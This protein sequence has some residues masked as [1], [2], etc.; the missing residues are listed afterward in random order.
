M[1][2][3]DPDAPKHA[4]GPI[5]DAARPLAIMDAPLEH[6]AAGGAD[7]PVTE[8]DGIIADAQEH[9]PDP[10]AEPVEVEIIPDCPGDTPPGPEP[11]AP[12]LGPE[13][14]P[15]APGGDAA[16]KALAKSKA[17][18][19]PPRGGGHWVPA[20]DRCA[21]DTSDS[22]SDMITGEHRGRIA[23]WTA[24]EVL[25]FTCCRCGAHWTRKYRERDSEHPERFDQGRPM[26]F[27]IACAQYKCSGDQQDHRR[28]VA[29]APYT[30]RAECRKWAMDLKLFQESF[31]KERPPWA[32]EGEEPIACP[33]G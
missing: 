8:I 16:D 22:I 6:D 19:R 28:A 20:S 2:P 3:P 10:V 17:R 23:R 27:L 1:P 21:T 13:P 25:V 7:D 32:H 11:P 26:G 12:G 14:A 24:T 15:K 29:G 4:P 31:K 30:Q 5:A 33:F 9:L 18:P